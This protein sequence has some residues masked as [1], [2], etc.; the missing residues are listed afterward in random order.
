MSTH[1]Y[2]PLMRFCF[3]FDV[4]WSAAL[5][6]LTE[7]ESEDHLDMLAGGVIK[8]LLSSKW[9]IYA[10]VSRRAAENRAELKV[11]Y[12]K[13]KGRIDRFKGS[14]QNVLEMHHAS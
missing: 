6:Y 8:Q 7:G 12:T 11:V 2:H 9:N 13:N 4:D 5:I 3:C 14:L 1:L 10:R